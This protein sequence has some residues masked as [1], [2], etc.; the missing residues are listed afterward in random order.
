M[1]T[2]LN[3]MKIKQN[4]KYFKYSLQWNCDK[5]K[6]NFR[7]T[8]CLPQRNQEIN[9]KIDIYCCTWKRSYFCASTPQKIT[10]SQEFVLLLPHMLGNGIRFFPPY[11]IY[12]L[13]HLH[14]TT[15]A[16][17]G[18]ICLRLSTSLFSPT[19]FVCH[20]RLFL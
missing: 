2:F 12:F 7:N 9:W 19:H 11:A 4:N 18:L 5:V 3:R 15:N 8:F 20:D 17:K 13:Q 6:R 10:S 16:E 1:F 14:F